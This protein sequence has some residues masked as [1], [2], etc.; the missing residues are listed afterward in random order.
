MEMMFIFSSLQ[1]SKKALVYTDILLLCLNHPHTLT[2]HLIHN[3]KYVHVIT[4]PILS[5][6]ALTNLTKVCGGSGTP[7]SGH[8]RVSMTMARELLSQHILQKSSLVEGRGPW[9]T[10]NSLGEL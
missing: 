2:A 6:N 1:H 4:G 7:K 9:V 5:L 10:I 8:V 3:T